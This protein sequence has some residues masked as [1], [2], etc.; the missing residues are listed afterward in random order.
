LLIG[1]FLFLPMILRYGAH[2]YLQVGLGAFI[3]IIMEHALPPARNHAPRNAS[4]SKI[5]DLFRLPSNLK[6]AK[7]LGLTIPLPLIARADEVIE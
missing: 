1:R 2:C 6:A 7:A 4:A 3:F 5:R